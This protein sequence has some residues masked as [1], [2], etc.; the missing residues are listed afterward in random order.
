MAIQSNLLGNF[1]RGYGQRRAATGTP[2]APNEMRGLLNPMLDA[3][4]QQQQM[5]DAQNLRQ[6][7]LNQQQSQFNS[8]QSLAKQ[9]MTMGGVGQALQLPIA[10]GAAKSM[11][12]LGG[13]TS[14]AEGAVGA[15]GGAGTAQGLLGGS[16]VPGVG[17]ASLQQVGGMSPTVL[18]GSAPSAGLLG[19]APVGG[20]GLA[21]GMFAGQMALGHALQPTMDKAGLPTAG[22]LGTYGGLPGAVTGAGIDVGKA[23]FNAIKNVSS[24]F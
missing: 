21:G 6:Q 2:L 14:T 20:L 24:L 18:G 5:L 7:A 23:A 4:L 1:F 16:T 15:A 17:T 9:G 8:Q 10:Y 3:Q 12:W 11:G 22:K 19:G 13:P